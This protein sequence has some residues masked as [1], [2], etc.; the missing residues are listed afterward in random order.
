MGPMSDLMG[1]LLHGTDLPRKM[2][3]YD[4]SSSRNSEKGKE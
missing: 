1:W 4:Y 2:G 3:I